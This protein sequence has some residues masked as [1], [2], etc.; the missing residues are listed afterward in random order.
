MTG[1]SVLLAHH[2]VHRRLAACPA[3]TASSS[4]AAAASVPRDC[5]LA[6]RTE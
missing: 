2:A 5:A 1:S 3:W 4:A 6:R